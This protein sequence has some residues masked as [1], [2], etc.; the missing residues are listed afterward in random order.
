MESLDT[1]I[2][3]WAIVGAI[4]L[5]LAKGGVMGVNN[6][7]I[8]VFA[9]IFPP[10]LSVGI[11]L[12][13]LVVGDWGAFY[14]YRRYAVWKYLIP[15]I[16]WTIGGVLVGWQLLDILDEDQVGRMIG[17]CLIGL[18]V[19]HLVRKYYLRNEK[20]PSPIPNHWAILGVVGF[21]GGFT[22]TVAN[23]AAPIMLLFFLAVELEKLQMLGTG[24]WFF[25]FLNLFKIPFLW[26]SG[27][28]NYEVIILDLKLAPFVVLGVF[29]GRNLVMRIPQKAFEIFALVV[30]VLASLR[31]IF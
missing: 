17:I 7:T 15:I 29:V 23:A 19:V 21:L 18:M 20:Q 13:L 10:K 9:I 14:L 6:I 27:L 3:I 8:A 2:F 11:I 30:T 5:G 25:L 12:L 24:A 22:S 16:P 31:L 4:I 1:H 28:I 26:S